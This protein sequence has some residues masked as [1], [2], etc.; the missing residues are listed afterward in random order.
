[1]IGKTTAALAV[2]ALFSGSLVAAPVLKDGTYT[3]TGA[4]R[5]VEIAVELTV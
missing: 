4:G 5:N 3:G 2:A 1:M